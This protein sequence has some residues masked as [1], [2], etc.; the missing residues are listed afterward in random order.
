MLVGTSIARE[1]NKSKLIDN[2]QKIRTLQKIEKVI[3]QIYCTL[4]WGENLA[5]PDAI[6]VDFV[7]FPKVINGNLYLEVAMFWFGG[8]NVGIGYGI[9]VG[10]SLI[11]NIAETDD[12]KAFFFG[13]EF[14]AVAGLGGKGFGHIGLPI[15]DFFHAYV[16]YKKGYFLSS[17]GHL[18][19]AFQRRIPITV[20]LG[21]SGGVNAG[22]AGHAFYF[23]KAK[24]ELVRLWPF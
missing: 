23:I 7:F 14:S 9:T 6:G 5:T 16:D 12:Y 20:G 18:R 3:D 13:G 11:F 1:I 19:G 24:S 10:G 21:V 8:W 2:D 17:Y 22:P 15:E 4:K